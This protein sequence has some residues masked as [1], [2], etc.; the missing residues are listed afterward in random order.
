MRFGF[1]T[2]GV[3][4]GLAT[5]IALLAHCGASDAPSQPVVPPVDGAVD[6]APAPI[7]S[8]AASDA[9]ADAEPPPP[10]AACSPDLRSV[11]DA[12]TGTVLEACAD[13]RACADGACLPACE[14]AARHGSSLGCEFYVARPRTRIGIGACFAAIVANMA[15]TPV[16]LTVERA[17]QTLNV[18]GMTR[19]ASGAGQDI[20]Y[21][22]L[23][24]GRIPA[25]QVA[26]V[27]LSQHGNDFACPA[28]VM[29][30]F[31]SE[32]SVSGTGRGETFHIT[33][34][35]PV[36][37]YDFSPFGGGSTALSSATLLLPTSTWGTNYVA[38][39]AYASPLNAVGQ[40]LLQVIAKEDDT[41]VKLLPK[42]DVVGGGGVGASSAGQVVSYTLSRGQFL[43]F[44]QDEELT[45]SAIEA[46]KPIGVVG[47][48]TCMQIPTGTTYCDAAHQQLPPVRAFG[49][50]Y[51]AVRYRNRNTVDESPPWRMVGAV[52]G[53]V[54]TYEPSTPA[55]APT[56]LAAGQ[57]VEFATGDAFTVS[58]QDAAHPFYVSAHMTGGSTTGIGGRGD[59]EFVNV[60]PSE[61][62]LRAYT[63]FTDP[64]Y[65]ETNLVVVRRKE[66]GAFA[67][68]ILDCAG[69]LSG[70]APAGTS[71]E[72]EFTRIDLVTGNFAPQGACDNGRHEMISAAPFTATVWGW[73]SSAT[74]VFTGNVSY[75]F[76]IG[77]GVKPLH[78][79]VFP[80][81]S[82]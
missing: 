8:D 79:V 6:D 22:P 59:P 10:I 71:G 50:R 67:D 37:A 61:Q 64:S 34:S 46:N 56:T 27:F 16:Q 3:A 55:G 19:L 62:Y 45:G 65:P 51:V 40:P 2:V 58:S 30:G 44:V 29:P 36:L 63:F 53:T 60:V 39:N 75:A 49:S 77:A 38:I 74:S 32:A 70:W 82:P 23:V 47:G 18:E 28:G 14:A 31:P 68:V 57:L 4:V 35:G 81:G 15:L 54:L 1:P 9:P 41:E 42:V 69:P 66:G 25:K 17:G 26:I 20:E 52:N 80:V 13:D 21:V 11:I 78:D 7:R 12:T 33:A 73:G 24:D 5:F 76:P 72:F 48:S 43:Q